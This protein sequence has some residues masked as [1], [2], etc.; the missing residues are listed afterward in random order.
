MRRHEIED[1]A[2]R[3]IEQVESGQPNEDYRVELKA[4]WPDTREAARRIAGHANAAHGEPI[5]WLIGVDPFLVPPFY[6]LLAILFEMEL[7]TF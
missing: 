6:V 5:L 1:W 3:I 2:L 4:Q 7:Q